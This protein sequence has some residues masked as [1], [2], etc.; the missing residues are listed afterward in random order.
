MV[1]AATGVGTVLV[2]LAACVGDDPRPTGVQ[3]DAAPQPPPLPTMPITNP[4]PPPDASTADCAD[5]RAHDFCTRFGFAP[6]EEGFRD[7]GLSIDRSSGTVTLSSDAVSAPSALD[8]TLP[9]SAADPVDAAR[10]AKVAAWP[11]SALDGSQ[12]P[13]VF[14]TKIRVDQ[15]PAQGVVVCSFAIAINSD[16]SAVDVVYVA[17]EP[18]AGDPD[19]MTISLNEFDAIGGLKLSQAVLPGVTLT[20]GIWSDLRFE[21]S[22]RSKTAPGS[23]IL[24]I[25]RQTGTLQLVSTSTTNVLLAWIGLSNLS[26]GTP[27][28]GHG[29]WRA[30]YDD[31]TLDWTGR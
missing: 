24:T 19:R 18:I 1:A 8:I 27:E 13:L 21:I 12:P 23:L 15:R 16:A 3:N 2:A 9:P 7:A 26:L 31:V 14:T 29:T 11:A 17:A 28:T 22:S 30:R 25:D 20:R 6:T 4:P 5:G 10:V